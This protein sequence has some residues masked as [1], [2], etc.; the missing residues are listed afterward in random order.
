MIQNDILPNSVAPIPLDFDS[1]QLG[2]R[3]KEEI[4]DRLAI[5]WRPN[6]KQIEKQLLQNGKFVFGKCS[7]DVPS[8]SVFK[9]KG[10]W[11]VYAVQ[12]DVRYL[13]KEVS[14]PYTY[15]QAVALL[16]DRYISLP[17]TLNKI[18]DYTNNLFKFADLNALTRYLIG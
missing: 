7:Q 13:V 18:N 8:I 9:I 6:L 16:F 5:N 10:Y 15:Q 2:Q 4:N 3:M 17:I 12:I 14:G 11:Y 1:W